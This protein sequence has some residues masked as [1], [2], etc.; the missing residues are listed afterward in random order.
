[1]QARPRLLFKTAIMLL[2]L[3]L[4]VGLFVAFSNVRQA[5]ALSG[6]P[7]GDWETVRSTID[8][9]VQSQYVATDDGEAGYVTT[10][11]ALK[12]KID[13][14]SDGVYLGEGDDAANA[15][16]LVDV[17]GS[18]TTL[19]P[20][21]SNRVIVT[22]AADPTYAPLI[23]ARVQA[24]RDAGFSTDII[25]YCLTGHS[26]SRVTMAYGALSASGYFGTPHPKVTGL[27]WGRQ[28]WNFTVT[29]APTYPNTLPL[30]AAATGLTPSSPSNANCTG[31]TPSTELIRCTAQAAIG[32]TGGGTEPTAPPL[33]YLGVDLR[34]APPAGGLIGSGQSVNLPFQNLFT[35]GGGLS[36]LPATGRTLWFYTRSPHTAGMA[37][38]GANMLGY[39]SQFLRWGIP[40][41]NNT[42]TTEELTDPGVAKHYQLNTVT[43]TGCNPNGTPGTGLGCGTDVVA[44]TI[45]APTV[46]NIT[47]TSADIARTASEPATSKIV[48]SGSD[49]SSKTVNN[50]V[51]NANKTVTVTGLNPSVTYTG[52]LVAYDDN[53]NASAAAPVSFTTASACT[54]GK[55]S[56]ALN[57][58][59]PH[60]GSYADY[61]AG[62]LSVDWTIHNTGTTA[63]NLV[64]LTSVSNTNGITVSSGSPA[65]YGSIAAGASAMRTIRYAGFVVGGYTVVGSWHT[66]N[67]GT[68]QDCAGTTYTYP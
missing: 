12:L 56:L 4:A 5:G 8:S 58:P 52:T 7:G 39:N 59:A 38:E 27:K 36:T 65:S 53:A 62:I 37:A 43:G 63:A 48:L 19:I 60:W 45:S 25:D 42:V 14:N 9:Y 30:G 1:M 3:L 68:A 46:S 22:T 32:P 15:P 51:L 18:Q 61:V 29:T 49:G 6:P 33:L 47:T 44:P 41:Y 13:S 40:Y 54:A 31:S 23:A 17:L 28:G 11:D 24:H 10:A 66:V 16:V 20:G 50:T 2:G 35:V 64:T 34:L 55:P 26:Q 21:T 67:S 57:V